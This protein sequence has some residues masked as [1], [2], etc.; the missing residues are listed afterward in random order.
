MK[1]SSDRRRDLYPETWPFP[2]GSWAIPVFW[3]VV[4]VLAVLAWLFT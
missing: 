1:E 4:I 3:L 2:V